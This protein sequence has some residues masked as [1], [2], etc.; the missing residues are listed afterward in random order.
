MLS[1]YSPPISPPWTKAAFSFGVGS[2]MPRLRWQR[3]WQAMEQRWRSR[4]LGCPS[5]R[6]DRTSRSRGPRG[7]RRR[8]AC[9]E[10]VADD[11]GVAALRPDADPRRLRQLVTQSERL[12]DGARHRQIGQ[13]LLPPL[14]RL[15]PGIAGVLEANPF[16]MAGEAAGVLDTQAG[17]A[18]GLIVA[19]VGDSG[20]GQPLGADLARQDGAGA[21]RCAT[22]PASAAGTRSRRSDRAGS[23]HERSSGSR[24]RP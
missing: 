14:H 13:P 23:R 16:A 9:R 8:R 24:G 11:L 22:D 3:S 4:C 6:R 1:R 12:G 15:L 20:D 18:A 5:A 19:M 2:I 17:R 10:L 7:G 21:L